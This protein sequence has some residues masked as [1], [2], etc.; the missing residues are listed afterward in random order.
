[1]VYVELLS[2]TLVSVLIAVLF[3]WYMRHREGAGED[4]DDPR[5]GLD[6]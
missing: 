6:L 3:D 4:N 1:V 2:A 5:E